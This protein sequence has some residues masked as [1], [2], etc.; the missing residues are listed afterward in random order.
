MSGLRNHLTWHLWSILL[1]S[2]LS[3]SSAFF[4]LGLFFRSFSRERWGLSAM[5]AEV[6]QPWALRFFSHDRWGLSVMSAEVLQPWALKSFNHEH[7]GLSALEMLQQ[8]YGDNTISFTYVLK[9]HK[10]FKE[11]CALCKD[12]QLAELRS[13]SEAGGVQWSLVDCSN[14]CKSSGYEKE[15]CLW[16]YPRSFRLIW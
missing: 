4:S 1:K 7:C 5:I 16:D 15:Q 2:Y 12:L 10:R 9:W 6:F 13:T 8:M 14:D 11:G 3:E